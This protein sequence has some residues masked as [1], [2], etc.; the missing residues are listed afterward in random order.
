M[1]QELVI[2]PKPMGKPAP[3]LT[4]L[5]EHVMPAVEYIRLH[6]EYRPHDLRIVGGAPRFMDTKCPNTCPL[7]LLPNLQGS[8]G[9][10]AVWNKH[11]ELSTNQAGAF[12]NWWDKL[13]LPNA[14]IAW[15][16]MF[17]GAIL[18]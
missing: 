18:Q 15:N 9:S 1:E 12:M 4:A 8:P 11:P 2:Q 7:G 13:N 3:V 16:L 14:I 6:A 17:P 5:P 10:G